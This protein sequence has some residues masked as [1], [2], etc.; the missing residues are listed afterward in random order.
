[1]VGIVAR[2]VLGRLSHWALAGLER[3]AIPWRCAARG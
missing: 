1:M 2:S 3:L